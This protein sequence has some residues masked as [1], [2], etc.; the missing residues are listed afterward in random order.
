LCIVDWLADLASQFLEQRELVRARKE[1]A[2]PLFARILLLLAHLTLACLNDGLLSGRSIHVAL[3]DGIGDL[4]PGAPC[5]EIVLLLNGRNG[6]RCSLGNVG[7]ERVDDRSVLGL[8]VLDLPSLGPLS[9]C[10]VDNILLLALGVEDGREG[11]LLA[12]YPALAAVVNPRSVSRSRLDVS[13]AVQLNVRRAC[14]EAFDVQGGQRDEVILV[15][16]VEVEDG[17]ADLLNRNQRL[18]RW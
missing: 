3:V 11:V 1:L 18:R 5:L 7:V 17:M 10:L 9:L 13:A 15:E 14:D 8:T 2:L 12:R 16:R 6:Q 4:L